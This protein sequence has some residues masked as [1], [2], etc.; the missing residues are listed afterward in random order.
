MPTP[1][2]RTHRALPGD[3]A[4]VSRLLGAALALF[5]LLWLG[6]LALVPVGSWSVCRDLEP[7]RIVAATERMRQAVGG[8][9]M[10]AVTEQR[11][12]LRAHCPEAARLPATA[13]ARVRFAGAGSRPAR[14][15]RINGDSVD[16]EYPLRRLRRP[17][18]P[19]LAHAAPADAA[20]VAV[21]VQRSSAPVLARLLGR[22]PGWRIHAQ[23]TPFAPHPAAR[24][25][26]GQDG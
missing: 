4:L 10:R 19:G 12:A 24:S 22:L 23:A 1:F 2:S 6:W 8:R 26:P 13:P 21:H 5:G 25:R 7:P 3:D 11:V 15:V 14:V 17:A 9:A 20:P 16:V 18:G